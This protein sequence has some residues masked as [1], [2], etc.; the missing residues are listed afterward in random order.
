MKDPDRQALTRSRQKITVFLAVVATMVLL[1]G[2]LMYL[3][4]GPQD[5]FPRIPRSVYWHAA[6]PAPLWAPPPAWEHPAP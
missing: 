3:I 6:G 2:S 5:G 1:L 4:E